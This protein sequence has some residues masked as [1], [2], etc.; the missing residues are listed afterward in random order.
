MWGLSHLYSNSIISTNVQDATKSKLDCH[1]MKE[2]V[3]NFGSEVQVTTSCNEECEKES[4]LVQ[5]KQKEDTKSPPSLSPYVESDWNFE[6][7]KTAHSLSDLVSSGLKTVK[8]N[9]IFVFLSFPVSKLHFTENFLFTIDPSS[10]PKKNFVRFR[11]IEFILI[12]Q[13]GEGML[14]VLI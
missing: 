2:I 11:P 10:I 5:E 3:G 14:Q 8:A 6:M 7:V 13:S 1:L 9:S 4:E 12:F